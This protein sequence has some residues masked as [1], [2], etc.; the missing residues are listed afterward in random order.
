VH[1]GDGTDGAIQHNRSKS[2]TPSTSP[3]AQYIKRNS[4][5]LTTTNRFES[6]FE[7]NSS[8]VSLQRNGSLT[9]LE[10]SV[11]RK[12]ASQELGLQPRKGN[13]GHKTVSVKFSVGSEGQDEEWT[14]DSTSQ[15]PET[16]R[17]SSIAQIQDQ[18]PEQQSPAPAPVKA[19]VYLSLSLLNRH[20]NRRLNLSV[21]L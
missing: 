5:H 14:E 17:T 13:Q 18:Q 4:S 21:D 9:Q 16:T 7:K 8:V 15:S 2:T 12:P 3:Q 11:N 1:G 19:P 6:I 20:L 10:K